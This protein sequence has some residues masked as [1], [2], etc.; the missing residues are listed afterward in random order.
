MIELGDKVKDPVTGFIGIAVA[1]TTWLHGCNRISVQPQDLNKDGAPRDAQVFDE[2][3]LTIIK[4]AVIKSTNA[5]S[6][7]KTGGPRDDRTALRRN[8]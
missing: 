3:Q 2:M 5:Y 4:K 7:P 6:E 8:G 1:K